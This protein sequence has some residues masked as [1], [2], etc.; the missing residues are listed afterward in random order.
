MYY[1]IIIIIII[2]HL[3]VITLLSELPRFDNVNKLLWFLHS[4]TG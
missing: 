4:L 2:M 1:I 3:Y